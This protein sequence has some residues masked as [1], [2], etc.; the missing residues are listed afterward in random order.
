MRRAWPARATAP[1]TVA[2]ALPSEMTVTPSALYAPCET[3]QLLRSLRHQYV[4]GAKK[5]QPTIHEQPSSEYRWSGRAHRTVDGDHGRIET[6]TILDS[7]EIDRDLPVPW[8][9]FPEAC[10]AAQVTRE[11]VYRRT[12]REEQALTREGFG[13][14]VWSH[15]CDRAGFGRDRR[16]LVGILHGTQREARNWSA[17]GCRSRSV[18]S[19]FVGTVA[20]GLG[21]LGRCGGG[22]ATCHLHRQI[23][24]V[25]AFRGPVHGPMDS[26]WGRNDLGRR[27]AG[28]RS[29]P[30]TAGLFHPADERPPRRIARQAPLIID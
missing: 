8:L 16:I 5:S 18:E 3:A 25:R 10:F 13:D 23:S 6:R 28:S 2:R 26:C 29:I 22:I 9:D 11:V 4:F 19:T 21:V 12:G 20:Y 1:R 7:S 15:W 17:H 30:R 24:A 14:G 27:L